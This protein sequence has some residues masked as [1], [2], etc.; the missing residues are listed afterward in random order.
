MADLLL[1]CMH[2]FVA[3]ANKAEELL[4]LHLLTSGPATYYKV[5]S[6]QLL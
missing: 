6:V 3:A 2:N 4:T 5:T 1:Q